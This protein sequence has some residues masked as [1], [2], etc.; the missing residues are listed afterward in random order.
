[1]SDAEKSLNLMVPP[2][3][4]LLL[5][6][7][8]SKGEESFLTH[9][10]NVKEDKVRG[11]KAR[12]Y[13]Q[14]E[15][16]TNTTDGILT[17]LAK[18]DAFKGCKWPKD[19]QSVLQ[20]VERYLVQHKHLYTEGLEQAEPAEGGTEGTKD[21]TLTPLQ[22]IIIEVAAL[23]AAA[24]NVEAAAASLRHA[25]HDR[26]QPRGARSMHSARTVRSGRGGRASVGR[27]VS[28]LFV[29]EMLMYCL[30]PVLVHGRMR[31]PCLGRRVHVGSFD[32]PA[33]RPTSRGALSR[34]GRRRLLFT[35]RAGEGYGLAASSRLTRTNK[36]WFSHISVHINHTGHRTYTDR[37]RE[38]QTQMHY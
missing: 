7:I 28:D 20:S 13:C 31:V 34:R 25:R 12:T 16:W 18:D 27:S 17:L 23:K 8:S 6:Q 32:A 26:V 22:Q 1:M 4:E 21:E 9:K 14:K 30:F 19:H 11:I 10:A 5:T 33:G 35:R 15:V 3:M 38:G 37:Q 29:A 36:I 24:A 2:R